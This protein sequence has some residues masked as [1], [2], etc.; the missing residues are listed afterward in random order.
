[1]LC[2]EWGSFLSAKYLMKI[3]GFNGKK[4]IKTIDLIQTN[5]IIKSSVPHT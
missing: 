3:I 1:M 4:I 5:I 2:L